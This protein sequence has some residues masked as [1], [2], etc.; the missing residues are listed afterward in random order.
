MSTASVATITV[1]ATVL[2]CS[3]LVPYSVAFSIRDFIKGD[4]RT[5]EATPD[6][7]EKF[8][9][10][11]VKVENG[12]L[13]AVNCPTWHPFQCP[14]GDCVPI[15]YLCDGSPDCGDEY[16][17]NKS[18]CTAATRP[19]VEETASFLKALLHAH[20]SNFLEK[21]F[22]PKARNQLEGMGGVDKVAVALSQSPTIEIFGAEMNF[23]EDEMEKMT[24]LLAEIASGSNAGLT[25]N[26]ADDFRFFVEKLHDTGFF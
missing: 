14:N 24:D 21:V 20:G 22:G 1:S 26:E 17:E 16:D 8:P 19:P 15:K 7:L 9:C 10:G 3:L 11:P 2:L 5:S 12:D 6:I 25:K 18:M 4:K 13:F 23:T